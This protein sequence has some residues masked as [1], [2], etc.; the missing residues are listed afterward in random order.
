MDLWSKKLL[1]NITNGIGLYVAVKFNSDI[2]AYSKD[3]VNWTETSLPANTYWGDVA[4]GNNR[5][6]AISKTN[7]AFSDDGVNWFSGGNL[8]YGNWSSLCYANGLF[9]TMNSDNNTIAYS[10]DGVTWSYKT[11]SA[12]GLT[13]MCYG[14]KK[15]VAVKTASNAAAYS[16]DGLSWTTVYL[17]QSGKWY[18]VTYGNGRYVAIAYEDTKCVYSDD[19]VTW[20]SSTLPSG[21][22]RVT[23]A[24]GAGKFVALSSGDYG[25]AYSDDGVTWTAFSS[26]KHT[27]SDMIFGKDKFVAIESYAGTGKTVLYSPDGINWSESTLPSAGNW[28][29]I[30]YG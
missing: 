8:T 16:T 12:T 20:T 13:K 26:G 30:T 1:L 9:F 19:G 24:Y 23:M 29:A 5:Y 3:G 2:A 25:G 11:N 21:S 7:T 15:F 6:V 4:Y 28:I 10:P 18:A 14:G 22:K 17:P 27:W